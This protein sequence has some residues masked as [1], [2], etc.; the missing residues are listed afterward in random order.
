[1]RLIIA[2]SRTFNDYIFLKDKMDAI[3][4]N[5]TEEIEIVSGAC[6]GVDLMGEA[7]AKDRGY[8]VRI[9]EADW[10]TIGKGA[11]WKRNNEMAAY[12]THCV[13]F[14]DGESKGTAMMIE[15]ATRVGLNLR[16]IKYL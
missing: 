11:G 15:I 7:Y 2:G 5:V 16:V 8:R 9:F 3:L 6:H 4:K 1:M 14:W 10:A 13:C 12:A